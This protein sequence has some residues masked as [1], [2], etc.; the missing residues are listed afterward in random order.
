MK[1]THT[2]TPPNLAGGCNTPSKKLPSG[3]RWF[4][5][6]GS[7]VLQ[8]ERASL[9][10]G[11]TSGFHPKHTESDCGTLSAQSL[12]LWDAEDVPRSSRGSFP[13]SFAEPAEG[14]RITKAVPH[15]LG[16]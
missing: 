12:Y 16:R 4:G 13:V 15:F 11:C 8:K 3:Q 9:K 14:S 10:A 1:N 2:H 6:A 7:R 5:K